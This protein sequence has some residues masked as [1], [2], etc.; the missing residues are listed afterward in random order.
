MAWRGLYHEDAKTQRYSP[1]NVPGVSRAGPCYAGR[2]RGEI[3]QV[4]FKLSK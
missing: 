4:Y 3:R 1:G 2:S